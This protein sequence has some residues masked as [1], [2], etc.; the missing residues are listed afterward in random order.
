MRRSC[1]A[2]GM[3]VLA[4]ACGHDAVYRSV[5]VRDGQVALGERFER[6]RPAERVSDSLFE[7]RP[8]GVADAAGVRIF[9]RPD[10]V[11][12]AIELEYAASDS[13]EALV[14]EYTWRLGPPESRRTER[15]R[16][17]TTVNTATWRDRQTELVIR[18][19]PQAAERQLTSRMT[20][21]PRRLP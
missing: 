1:W 2:L 8:D 5:Q 18:W 20:D 10:T 21:R 19:A 11:V 7:L 9:V 4:A 6:A 12:R 15:S 3:L 17:D 13:F 16:G 14:S